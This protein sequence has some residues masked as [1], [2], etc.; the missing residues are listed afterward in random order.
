MI[1][2]KIFSIKRGHDGKAMKAATSQMGLCA[3]QMVGMLMVLRKEYAKLGE[4][5]KAVK[6]ERIA[7]GV[8]HSLLMENN[9]EFYSKEFSEWIEQSYRQICE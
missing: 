6:Y 7:K 4:G 9:G 8:H 5:E 3:E 2:K 1:S